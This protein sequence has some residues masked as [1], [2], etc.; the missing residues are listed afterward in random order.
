MT[1]WEEDCISC[2][3]R[4]LTGKYSHWCNEWD[5][6]PIDETCHPFVYCICDSNEWDMTEKEHIRK[7][8]EKE[9]LK[10]IE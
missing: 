10:G 4:V 9:L 6:A 7:E 8:L 2:W 3:G 1:E 5:Y